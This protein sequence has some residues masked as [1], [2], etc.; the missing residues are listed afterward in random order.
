MMK[1]KMRSRALIFL[2]IITFTVILLVLFIYFLLGEGLKGEEQS[3]YKNIIS[4]CAQ[5]KDGLIK[6]DVSCTAFMEE[7][8]YEGDSVCF[9]FLV[10]TPSYEIENYSFCEQREKI[11]WDEEFFNSLER[12]YPVSLKFV[13]E[14]VLF[15]KDRLQKIEI[16]LI[17]GDAM[18]ELSRIIFD[19][20]IQVR[21]LYVEEVEIAAYNGYNYTEDIE[22]F[23]GINLKGVLLDSVEILQISYEEEEFVVDAE[24]YL[25]GQTYKTQFRMKSINVYSEHPEESFFVR[26][27]Q[28]LE[29]YRGDVMQNLDGFFI[30]L[31][32]DI[33]DQE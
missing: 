18:E 11:D 4:T 27:T 15:L 28:D 16:S 8:A 9:D 5:G 12:T 24:V 33:T 26:N 13:F 7:F 31:D 2:L 3:K 23:K 14:K 1:L 17:K 20:S 25:L 22:L 19:K 30:Y 29:K 21:H 6:D 10:L 32:Q